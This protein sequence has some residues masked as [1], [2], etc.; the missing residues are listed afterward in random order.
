MFP[1][2]QGM[3]NVKLDISAEIDDKERF[4]PMF[5][6][7]DQR[8]EYLDQIEKLYKEQNIT[9]GRF[10]KLVGSNSLDTW[11][12]LMGNRDLGIR[13]RIDDY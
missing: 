4:Q 9:I 3:D 1:F 10:A 12:T 5:D 8:Q 6:R 7:I 13:C 2:D 11:G